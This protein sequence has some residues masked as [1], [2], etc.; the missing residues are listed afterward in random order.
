MDVKLQNFVLAK[1]TAFFTVNNLLAKWE[2]LDEDA[3][4]N[5]LIGLRETLAL[6]IEYEVEDNV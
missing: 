2:E 5:I 6:T 1:I 3:K 4:L